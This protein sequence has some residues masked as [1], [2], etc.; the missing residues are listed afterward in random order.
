MKLVVLSKGLFGLLTLS[1]ESYSKFQGHKVLDPLAKL[2]NYS[3]PDLQLSRSLTQFS[4]QYMY[5]SKASKLQKL[6]RI[7]FFKKLRSQ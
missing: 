6:N 1:S 5:S 4:I 7:N 2:K 3:F